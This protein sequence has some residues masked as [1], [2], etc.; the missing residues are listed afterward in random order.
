MNSPGLL[1]SRSRENTVP[2]AR[3][4]TTARLRRANPYSRTPSGNAGSAVTSPRRTRFHDLRH[5][6]CSQL[7]ASGRHGP[8]T[9]QALSRPAEFSETWGTYARPALAVEGV[10]VTAFG[11]MFTGAEPAEGASAEDS[12]SRLLDLVCGT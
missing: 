10:T 5:S 11:D 6:Y 12:W 8:K 1:A 7:G 2:S 3:P 9:V 4:G